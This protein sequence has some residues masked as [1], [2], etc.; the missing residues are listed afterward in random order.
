FNRSAA[1][2]VSE[3]GAIKVLEEYLTDLQ[4]NGIQF[5]NNSGKII[6]DIK[7]EFIDEL[8]SYA[9]SS[10]KENIEKIKEAAEKFKKA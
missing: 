8:K 6:A 5:S 2:K 10:S 3:T 7:T 1:K 9:S 4:K